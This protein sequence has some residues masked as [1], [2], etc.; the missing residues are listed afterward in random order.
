M[1]DF[2]YNN[3]DWFRYVILMSMYCFFFQIKQ[4]FLV[5]NEF[6]F[7]SFFWFDH[8]LRLQIY[9]INLIKFDIYCFKNIENRNIMFELH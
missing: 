2:M 7:L 6:Y 5:K 8:P 1:C 9:L 4:Q 3:L